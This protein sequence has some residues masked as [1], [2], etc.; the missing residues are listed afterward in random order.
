MPRE[1]IATAPGR[2][3]LREYEEPTLGDHELRIRS[4]F[5][6]PKHGTESHNFRGT[7][8]FRETK[9]SDEYRIFLP[10]PEKQP[11]FPLR[12]GNMTV[13]R[14][15]EVGRKVTRFKPGD[16]VYGHL[17]IRETHTIHE[18]GPG[19]GSVPLGSGVRESR[20]HLLPEGMTPQQAVLL[21]PA[22]FALA[23]V[24]DAKVGLG[25]RVAIFGL[26]A[27]GLLI[28]QMLR[29]N[30]VELIFAVDPIENRRNLALKFGADAA[31]D[32][33]QHDAGYEI[34]QATNKKGVDVAIDASG[35]YRALQ[36]A[37]RATHYSGTVVTCS[38]YQGTGSALR[39]DEE[40]FL[41]R[42]TLKVSMPV[43]GNPSRDYPAWDDERIEDTVFRLMLGGK[44][45]PE[46]IVCPVVPFEKAAETYMEMSEH[47]EKGVK[48][49]VTFG[50]GK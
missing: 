41:A 40:F 48:M 16:R 34:K 28:V 31:Y 6:S 20:L 21:D 44:L 35:S 47:P 24:R 11:K 49:G 23:A 45:D 36:A 3:E 12:L 25:D 4:E 8:L 50:E 42:M 14:I 2:A 46:G 18:L 37:I 26:G 43:W 15:T 33:S 9:F 19:K 1:L 5:A 39:L 27:I 17:P 32:P 30:G 10:L 7:T 29:L 22:H 38:Y 13:G